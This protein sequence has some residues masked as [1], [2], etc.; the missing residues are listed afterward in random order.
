MTE[1]FEQWFG[2]EYLQLYP[3]RDE[4]DAVR[5]VGLVDRVARLDGARV[6]DLACGSGRHA[7]PLA[8][9]G[10]SVF[11]ID[12]SM[13]LLVRANKLVPPVRGV[14]RGDMRLLP[15]RDAAFDL[16]VNLF[17]SFGYFADD[18]QHVAVLRGVARVLVP[19]GKLFLDYLNA[20]AVREGLVV[21]EERQFGE[22]RV[23]IERKLVDDDRFIVKEM[24]LV[25]DGRTFMERVRLFSPDDLAGLMH[26]AGLRVTERFGSYAGDEL[27]ATTPRTILVAER[28]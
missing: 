28:P 15:L 12:L 16:V 25:D 26:D 11:G 20:Q 23:A 18:A 8:E 17:T 4:E 5:A 10:A 2:E 9:R 7:M 13:P 24:H 6:L 22:H 3:H 19:G 27:T 21:R 14:V 1:W